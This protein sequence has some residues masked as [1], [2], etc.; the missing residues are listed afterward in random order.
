LRKA[1]AGKTA[2]HIF[3]LWNI[4]TS[5]ESFG[6]SWSSEMR[7]GP[8][9]GFPHRSGVKGARQAH[10]RELRVQSGGR[11]I[12]VLYAFDPRRT[13]ILL[14]G[15]DKSGDKRFYDRMIAIA[16]DLYDAYLDELRRE[17]LLP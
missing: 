17:G 1:D 4:I 6:R 2:S 16:D 7:H 11:P 5:V 14:I 9:L 15:G 13:A 10:M 3:P 12:R 8:Q